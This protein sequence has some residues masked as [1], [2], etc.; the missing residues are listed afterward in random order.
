MKRGDEK[1]QVCRHGVPHSVA[2]D[3]VY[4]GDECVVNAKYSYCEKC[5]FE[6][7]AGAIVGAVLKRGKRACEKP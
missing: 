7:A 5:A 3:Q 2:I 1:V 4:V 6:A